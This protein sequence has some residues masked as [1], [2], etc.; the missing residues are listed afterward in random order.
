MLNYLLMIFYLLFSVVRDID[1]SVIELNDEKKKIN[2][3]AF[4]WKMTF[5][6]DC[7]MQAQEIIFSRKL[8]IR[9]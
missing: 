7:S 2:D 4:Q 5:K 6:P 8:K 3:W 9:Y 1:T